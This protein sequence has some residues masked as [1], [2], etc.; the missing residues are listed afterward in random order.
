MTLKGNI[1]K[2][3]NQNKSISADNCNKNASGDGEVEN[4]IT[5]IKYVVR[6]PIGL[7]Q[8]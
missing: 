4:L 3:I 5:F 2:K 1:M 8:D 6:H 7:H